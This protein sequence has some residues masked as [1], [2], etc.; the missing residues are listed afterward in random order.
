MVIFIQFRFT[1]YWIV[2]NRMSIFSSF[3]YMILDYGNFNNNKL[4]KRSKR[5][6][7]P[8][9]KKI[10]IEICIPKTNSE[11]DIEIGKWNKNKRM[12]MSLIME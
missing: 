1:I 2:L 6:K 9:T 5:E 8:H 4:A 10:G 11:K 12:E 7:T 3:L